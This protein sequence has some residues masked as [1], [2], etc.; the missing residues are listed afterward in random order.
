M[1]SAADSSL[2]F[3]ND[4]N[5]CIASGEAVNEYSFYKVHFEVKYELTISTIS[6]NVQLDSAV[7]CMEKKV[8]KTK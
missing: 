5:S 1:I 2:L 8:N 4:S 7:T 6:L 3:D